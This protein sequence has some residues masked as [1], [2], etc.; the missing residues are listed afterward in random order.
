MTESV[1][2]DATAV[3]IALA[4]AATRLGRRH[5][6]GPVVMVSLRWGHVVIVI[7]IV[8][9]D[10][11]GGTA[12]GPHMMMGVGADLVLT[13]RHGVVSHVVTTCCTF[14]R[15]ASQLHMLFPLK[16]IRGI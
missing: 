10:V 12:V 14:N 6:N 15:N 13:A 2:A 5:S 4:G 3:G 1:I 8:L 7:Q 11:A 9:S 16:T